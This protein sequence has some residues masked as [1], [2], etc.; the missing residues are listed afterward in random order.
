MTTHDLKNRLSDKDYELAAVMNREYESIDN[1]D[2]YVK[3][4]TLYIYSMNFLIGAAIV[5][6]FLLIYELKSKH[7]FT[8]MDFIFPKIR[9][10][11][12]KTFYDTTHDTE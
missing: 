6:G 4:K 10:P 12:N 3:Q 2:Q 8:S 5:G 7:R 9:L 1:Y 11:S